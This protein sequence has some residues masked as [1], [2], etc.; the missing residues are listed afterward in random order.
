MSHLPSNVF[1]YVTKRFFMR[2]APEATHNYD[3]T[4]ASKGDVLLHKGGKG[5]GGRGSQ[6]ERMR[7]MRKIPPR[8][9]GKEKGEGKGIEPAWYY[10]EQYGEDVHT[11][12]WAMGRIQSFCNE[13]MFFSSI[14]PWETPCRPCMPPSFP[15]PFTSSPRPS[16]PPLVSSALSLRPPAT[17]NTH[18]H[19]GL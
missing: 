7:F 14:P 16:P 4:T 3:G 6:E 17:E 8:P 5:A 9:V 11:H 13:I 18:R 19:H 1:T 15:S 2:T 12:K 10:I